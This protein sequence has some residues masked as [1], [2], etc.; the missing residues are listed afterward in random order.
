MSEHK[1]VRDT[2]TCPFCDS[3]AV[4]F[5]GYED[6]GGDYGDQVTG[7]Y[8]CEDCGQ[9]IDMSDFDWIDEDDF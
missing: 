1:L 3:K 9:H 7:M 8:E 4:T 2:S 6:G 5:L